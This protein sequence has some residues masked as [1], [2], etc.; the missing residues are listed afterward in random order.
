[1]KM[2]L[3]GI[4]DQLGGGFARYSTDGEWLAPHFEKMLYDNALLISAISEAYQITGKPLY[5]KAIEETMGFIT[6]EFLS[7][8][9]GFY[10]ALDADS[11]GEEGRYYVWDKVETDRLLGEQAAAFSAVYDISSGGNWEGKNILRIRDPA[12]MLP[13]E[14]DRACR[15][16]LLKVR[17]KRVRPQLDDKILLGW[18]ALMISACCRAFAALGKTEYRELAVRAMQFIEE[19]FRGKGLYH[20]HHTYKKGKATVPAFLDDYAYLIDA[21]IQLQEITGNGTYLQKAEELSQLVVRHFSEPETGLFY[22]TH[23][24]QD[25][26]VL[27]KKE[28]YDGAT[29]SGNA[30]MAGNLLYL[31]IALDHGEWR[32]RSA[33]MT[34]GMEEVL[35]KYPGSFGVW[36]TLINAFAYGMYEI[37]LGGD[38]Q[39]EKQTAFLA[40]FVPNRIFQVTSADQPDFPLLRNK[41]VSGLSQFFLC[42]NYACQQPVTEPDELFQLMETP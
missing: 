20:F 18:N 22:Y 24:E 17:E 1:D 14:T 9:G 19:K 42:R 4:Y 38:E 32:T 23:E 12:R 29:A 28:I 13:E 3:G 5:R 41:P 10:A 7:P 35:L 31:G 27:R 6:R 34:K 30:V 2:I 25:D 36:A 11:E 15:Q 8:E 26:A 33:G 37:V 21:C 40:R 16:L 39:Q